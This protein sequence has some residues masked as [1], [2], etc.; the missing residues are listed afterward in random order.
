VKLKLQERLGLPFLARR[1]RL[2]VEIL[3]PEVRLELTKMRVAAARLDASAFP[4]SYSRIG[5]NKISYQY[6]Y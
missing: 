5:Y 1:E 6:L 4:A 2:A 3:E